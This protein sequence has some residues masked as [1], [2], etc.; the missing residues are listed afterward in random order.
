MTENGVAEPRRTRGETPQHIGLKTLAVAWA[1]QQG[2]PIAAAEVSFPHRKFRVDAAACAPTLKAP[3]RSPKT[4]L[5]SVLKASAV[6]ECKQARSDLLR[7]NKR[8]Q[9]SSER[10]RI[11]EERRLRLEELLK[12]HLPHLRTGEGLFS[13]YDSY[14]LTECRH[15][16]YRRLLRE[17]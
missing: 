5:T 10:L 15:N 8:R 16:G 13:E 12:V 14:R 7:D 1:R 17:I 2:M 4:S 3:S 9:Q 6:F 11:L